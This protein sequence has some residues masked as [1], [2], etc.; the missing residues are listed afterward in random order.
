MTC[1]RGKGREHQGAD[2]AAGG[3]PRN[4]G[5]PGRLA[6]GLVEGD[7]QYTVLLESGGVEDG[8]DLLPKP[9]VARGQPTRAAVD[10]RI[11]V[12]VMAEVGEM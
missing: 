10:A 4:R 2:A 6:F 5:G 8:R 12:A 3:A 1:R 11:V 7:D 9:A